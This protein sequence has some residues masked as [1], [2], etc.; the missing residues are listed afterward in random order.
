MKRTI[1]HIATFVFAVTLTLGW[2]IF[3]TAVSAENTGEKQG[4]LLDALHAGNDVSCADC[5]GD[6]NKR[7]PVP[8]IQC[9]ECHDTREVAEATAGLRPTNPHDNRHYSTEGDCNLCH[10]QHR[11]SENFCLPCHGRFDFVVP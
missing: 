7:E 10:H 11:T 9:L 2:G 8:M 4:G 5:H 1:L 6:D 3:A